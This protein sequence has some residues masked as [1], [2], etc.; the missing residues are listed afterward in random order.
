MSIS[1]VLSTAGRSI[2]ELAYQCSP[3]FLTG[4]I[5]NETLGGVLPII[6][7]TEAVGF[8]NNLVSGSGLSDPDNFFASWIPLP[9]GSLINNAVGQYPFANQTVAANALIANPINVSMMM[10]CPPRNAGYYVTKMATISSL[11]A[12]LYQHNA[13]GGMYTILTPGYIY[14][15]MIMTGMRDATQDPARAPQ[16]Q[17]MFDFIRPLTQESEMQQVTSTLMSKLSNGTQ[18]GTSWG[19]TGSGNPFSSVV[20]SVL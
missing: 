17:F 16:S 10:M 11:Q 2:A 5:A 3:I 14:T 1:S 4:G 19:A 12:A 13:M 9:G 15:N 8:V 7:F 20:S 6:T 18:T